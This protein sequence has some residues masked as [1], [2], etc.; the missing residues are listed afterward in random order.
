MAGGSSQVAHC[1]AH[2]DVLIDNIVGGGGLESLQTSGSAMKMRKELGA[3]FR[4]RSMFSKANQGEADYPCC[5]DP[6]RRIS[7]QDATLDLILP[8]LLTDSSL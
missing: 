6:A 3:H 7:A 2:N 8:P 1:I 4:S 5:S